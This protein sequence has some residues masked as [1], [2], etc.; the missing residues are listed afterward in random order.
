MDFADGLL[1]TTNIL[2]CAICNQLSES[3]ATMYQE[4]NN[5]KM[6]KCSF[7]QAVI[8][9]LCM[10]HGSLFAVLRQVHE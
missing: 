2:E 9:T 10:V 4:L 5:Y 6:Q 7:F 8:S 3:S 1:A